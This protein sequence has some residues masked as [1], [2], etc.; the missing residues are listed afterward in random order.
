A[1]CPERCA[2]AIQSGH[3]TDIA[4]QIKATARQT[5]DAEGK[6]V[7]PGLV[8]AHL[9][10]DKALL[11]AQ[12]PAQTGTFQEALTATGSLKQKFTV[13]DIQAR[14]RRVI[15]DE[16]AFGTTALR[17]HVE[18]DPMLQLTSLEALLP[19]KQDYAWGLTLQLAVF[20]QEGI[21][22]QP[23]TAALLRQ[24]LQMGGDLIGSAPYV[25]PDP[26]ANIRTVFDLAQDFD[27]DVDFHL[28]FLDDDAPLL[29]PVVA[30][31]TVWR[32]WQGRVCLGHLTR[33]AG[34]APEK[35]QDMAALLRE[36]DIAV[37]ALPASDLYMMARQDTH[38]V[39]RGVAPIQ[40]LIELGVTAGVATNNV[41]NLFTPFGDGDLLKICTLIAQ[42][43][44]LGTAANHQQCLE[45]VTT[46][47]ARAIG[48]QDY[49][50]APGKS[51]DLVIVEATSVSEAIGT[52][53]VGRTT[54]KGGRVVSQ[55][56]VQRQLLP[57]G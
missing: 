35:L 56:Q 47:A 40:Q 43:L 4:P 26:A 48:L 55:T 39:R 45:M 8:D 19:L 27:C 23:G 2:I 54:L 46:Q 11:L 12:R 22:N 21:T 57:A 50:I 29:L 1:D 14:A 49:G 41:Q 42:T 3:I 17:S 18:V 6:L 24:A 16:I 53:P 51:A 34:L 5:I 10:L 37:L 33:L 31:E 30:A 38:N 15:E 52:A 9:H 28:D 25:D 44:Q 13:E 32:G 20:A 7:I 36:A